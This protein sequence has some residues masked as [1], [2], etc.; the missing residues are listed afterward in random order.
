M[1]SSRA[2][3]GG[4]AN[5]GYATH[6]RRV[7]VNRT[8]IRQAAEAGKAEERQSPAADSFPKPVQV[9]EGRDGFSLAERD[10]AQR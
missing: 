5:Q 2:A 7:G 10:E 3:L 9:L 8:T 6:I 1:T 4:V